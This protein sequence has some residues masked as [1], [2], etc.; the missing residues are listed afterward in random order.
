M[1]TSGKST[2]RQ[3]AKNEIKKELLEYSDGPDSWSED[4]PDIW[5]T[6]FED[7]NWFDWYNL[8]GYMG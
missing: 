5:E 3:M 2:T 7:N 1:R 4:F 6:E 8:F